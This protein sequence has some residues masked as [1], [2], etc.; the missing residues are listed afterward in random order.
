MRELNLFILNVD[1][2]TTLNP[3]ENAQ[4]MNNLLLVQI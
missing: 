2:M 4:T 3:I 1:L